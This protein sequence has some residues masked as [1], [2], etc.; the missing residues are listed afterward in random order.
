M[1]SLKKIL[2]FLIR[3]SK[4]KMSIIRSRQVSSQVLKTH[5][6]TRKQHKVKIQMLKEYIH[7]KLRH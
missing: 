1:I 7:T 3:R 5:P 2:D 6:G 4:E